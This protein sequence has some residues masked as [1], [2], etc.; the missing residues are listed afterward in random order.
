MTQHTIKVRV[1]T[2]ERLKLTTLFRLLPD[3]RPA[4]DGWMLVPVGEKT[5]RKLEAIGGTHDEALNV[6]VDRVME[7]VVGEITGPDRRW[8]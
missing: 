6:L 5:L 3:G 7:R 2:Y 8:S 4:E 1:E